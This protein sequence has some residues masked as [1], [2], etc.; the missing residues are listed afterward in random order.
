MLSVKK[1]AWATHVTSPRL[2]QDRNEKK[3]FLT[4]FYFLAPVKPMSPKNCTV[5]IR[6]NVASVHGLRQVR[7][8]HFLPEKNVHS[9][10]FSK[11]L[12]Q[13]DMSL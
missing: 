10:K 6:E 11:K 9:L 2:E 4:F 1:E 7:D 3:Q 13:T 12:S 8:S 5:A